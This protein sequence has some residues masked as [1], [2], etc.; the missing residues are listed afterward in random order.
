MRIATGPVS[1]CPAF[2]CC[3]RRLEAHRLDKRTHRETDPAERI[4]HLDLRFALEEEK[5]AAVLRHVDR[6]EKAD[7]GPLAPHLLGDRARTVGEGLDVDGEE[8]RALELEEETAEAGDGHS[9][10]HY[11]RRRSGEIVETHME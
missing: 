11:V 7:R 2:R 9:S 4:A 8:L 10:R 6:P 3:V 5:A 1:R